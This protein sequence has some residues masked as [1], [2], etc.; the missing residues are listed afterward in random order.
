MTHARRPFPHYLPVAVLGIAVAQ[1]IRGISDKLTSAQPIRALSPELRTCP[2]RSMQSSQSNAI[3]DGAVVRSVRAAFGTDALR[4][5]TLRPPLHQSVKIEMP[6]PKT[7]SHA[8]EKI[9][10][11]PQPGKQSAV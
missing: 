7:F 4:R 6:C 3:T 10:V 2:T 9:G 11:W 5:L 8:L 1:K